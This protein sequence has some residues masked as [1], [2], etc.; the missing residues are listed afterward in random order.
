M[1]REHVLHGAC[2]LDVLRTEMPRHRARMNRL[3]EGR[4]VESDREG[5]YRPA[6]EKG[7]P[8]L[9]EKSEI[10]TENGVNFYDG[11]NIFDNEPGI[12]YIDE[13]CHYTQLGNDLLADFIAK[14]ILESVDFNGK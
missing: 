7:Y 11:T 12:I 10:L 13:C 8:V 3:V 4:V 5:S 14:S 9:A 1:L 6:V 2:F